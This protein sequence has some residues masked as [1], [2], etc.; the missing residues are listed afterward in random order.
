LY[1]SL[2]LYPK[3]TSQ[4][5]KTIL[6]PV[7]HLRNFVSAGAFAAANG[8]LPAADLGAIKQAYQALQTPLKGT[9]QQN[10]LYE[11]LLQLGVVNSSVSL[12]DLSKLLKD[13]NFGAN[14]TSDKGMRMLLKPLSKLKSVSQDLYTAEDDFWKIYSWAIEKKRLEDSFLKSGIK[15]S[16]YFTRNGKEIQLTDQFLKEEAA[17]II[18]NNI[19][20]YDYVSD[21]VQGLRKLPIGNF[22]SFPA[23]IARTGTN[24]VRR[25]LREINE[26]IEITDGAGK[27][28]RTVKPFESIGYT[29][30]FGFTTTVA[31]VPMGTA[32]AFQ[33]LYD[34]TDEEREAIRRFAASWSKNSTLLPIKD[35]D[36]NFKYV[37]FSHANA[38]DTLIRPLQSVVNA[39]QDGRTDQDGMMDDFT[40][41]C[42]Q[43]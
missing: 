34:V 9:R 23:E 33:A 28:L 24:I 43:P 10:D 12:G 13:V 14:M 2:I 27:V 37:D 31:A 30:L 40:K 7:T 42:L 22:V 41:V 11:E 38:Y 35:S 18:K 25:A 17:D 21:F 6:S 16:D 29:R 5:A 19:P 3:A 36:G 32:A 26:T 4:I 20:N 39:V 1:E 15:R 8:I